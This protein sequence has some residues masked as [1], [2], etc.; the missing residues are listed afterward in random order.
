MV[1][2]LQRGDG[3][4]KI[5]Y[6][7]KLSQRWTMLEQQH[8]SLRLL[9]LRQG[10]REAEADL[11]ER[12]ARWRLRPTEFFRPAMRLLRY[13]AGCRYQP[14]DSRHGRKVG[15]AVPPSIRELAMAPVLFQTHRR[16]V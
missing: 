16:C 6:T 13:V 12:F 5:G 7:S 4:V 11:H 9:G 3:C 2:F 8:G 1:Y 14:T 15:N 10:G